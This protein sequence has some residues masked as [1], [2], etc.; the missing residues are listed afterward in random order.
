MKKVLFA[1]AI[2][3]LSAAPALAQ[4]VGHVNI[5]SL[6]VL[7]PEYKAAMVNLEAEQA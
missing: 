2:A 1:A 5:D 4:K 3:L 6:L 7:M